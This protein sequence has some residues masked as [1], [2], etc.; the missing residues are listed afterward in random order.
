MINKYGMELSRH[1]FSK[2]MK[3]K[4]TGVV[5]R[6]WGANLFRSSDP[7]NS[8]C[9]SFHLPPRAANLSSQTSDVCRIKSS[10]GE[11]EKSMRMIR[12]CWAARTAES[13][14]RGRCGWC[15]FMRRSARVGAGLL[16]IEAGLSDTHQFQV[17]SHSGWGDQLPLPLQPHFQPQVS[18]HME[19]V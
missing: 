19:N 13:S 3:G 15:L 7:F 5:R 10:S 11:P 16:I 2:V 12:W 17:C 6:R 9:L 4:E 1:Y 18:P 8:S 14:Q